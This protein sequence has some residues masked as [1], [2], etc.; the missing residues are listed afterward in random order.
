MISGPPFILAI[1]GLGGIGKTALVDAAVRKVLGG[2]YFEDVVWV[3]AAENDPGVIWLDRLADE[4]I[5][6][7]SPPKDERLLLRQALKQ[8]PHLIVIDNLGKGQDT[9]N[10]LTEVQDLIGPSK[11]L[12]TT[13]EGV[14]GQI[15]ALKLGELR[16]DDAVQVMLHHAE[17][18]GLGMY[19]DQIQNHA[20]GIYSVI[21]GN[22]L[23]LKLFV[24]LLD[25][26]PLQMVLEDFCLS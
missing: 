10:I 14:K 12:L 9:E 6:L 13:R 22:P 19:L 7:D 11:V 25:V 20:S 15:W 24:G 4:L 21:G 8:Q 23:A 1:V 16:K 2:F 3:R 5:P 17:Q 18:I 26:L